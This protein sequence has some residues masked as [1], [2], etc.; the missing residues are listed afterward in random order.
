MCLKGSLQNTSVFSREMNMMGV[1]SDILYSTK[2][3]I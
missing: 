3:R 1:I 2:I